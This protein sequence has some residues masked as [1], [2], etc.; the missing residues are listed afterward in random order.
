MSYAFIKSPNY[1]VGRGGKQIEFIVCHWIVGDVSS[2]DRTFTNPA[3]QVSA[4][5]AVQ[6]GVVHQYVQEG[7]TAW[8]AISAN[9]ISIGIEHRGGPNTPIDDGTYEES[10]RLIA[11]ICQ[12]HNKRFPLRRHSE[13]VA[14]ACPGTLDLN[15]L[16][17]RV[18]QLLSGNITQPQGDDDMI[19]NQDRDHIRVGNSEIKGWDFNAVHT[20]QYD[21]REMQAWVGKSWRQ[22]YGEAW[23]EGGAWREAR[24]AKLA[25][26]DALAK[27]VS[28]LSSRPTKAEL[29]AVADQLKASQAKVA[30]LEA[31]VPDGTNPDDI[32]VTRKFWGGLFDKIKTF[33]GKG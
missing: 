16:N 18:D 7:D 8:H 23:N 33:I 20:G 17:A 21:Q 6:S 10:A 31:K 27:Q 3:S 12:R 19:T 2:A 26:Y 32:V 14:T 4:H 11:N 9:P 28:E 22:F 29:Q 13:F 25:G 15:R 24:N 5:Y 1:Y 30:E